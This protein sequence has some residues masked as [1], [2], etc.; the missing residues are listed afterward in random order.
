GAFASM[1]PRRLEYSPYDTP[2][3]LLSVGLY[4][5]IAQS[6][7][8]GVTISSSPGHGDLLEIPMF[9]EEGFLTALLFENVPGG[10][11]EV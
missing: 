7:P 4:R 1:F 2:Q 9:T 5:G 6:E 3:R 11:L 8:R 10:D